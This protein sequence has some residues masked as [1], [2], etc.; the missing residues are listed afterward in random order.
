MV[1]VEPAT[2]GWAEALAQG[3]DTFASQFGVRVEEGWS[4]FPEAIPTLADAARR[5]GPDQWG[6][7]LVFDDD[8]ALVGNGGWKGAPVDGAAEL[9]YA[10]A[11]SRQGRGIATAVVRQ[12]LERGRA[13]GLHLAVAHTVA[14]DSASTTVLQRCG[15]AKVAELVDPDDGPIWRWELQL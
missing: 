2:R 12:L 1:R 9:G 11:P 10:V 3:D 7:H 6:W 5:A 8:G 14:Q 4:G 13:A 15:F